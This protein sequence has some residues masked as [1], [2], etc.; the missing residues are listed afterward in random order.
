MSQKMIKKYPNRRLYDM[1]LSIYI[2]LE[3][4]KRYVMEHTPFKIIDAKTQQDVTCQSLIQIILEQEGN[5]VAPIFT[6]EM[7]E[8]IVRFYGNPLQ[9]VFQNYLK[10]SLDL[11]VNQNRQMPLGLDAM[12]IVQDQDFLASVKDLT[13]RNVESW[14]QWWI[15]L[16]KRDQE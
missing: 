15:D 5:T 9:T 10:T 13:N 14:T 1:D 2:T 4:L 7:L 3:D 16:Q 11:F 12:K 8:H 6:Q